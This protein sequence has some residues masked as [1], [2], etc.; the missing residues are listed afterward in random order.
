MLT[1]ARRLLVRLFRSSSIPQRLLLCFLLLSIVP[2]VIIGTA[3]YRQSNA[4]MQDKIGT[5]SNEILHQLQKTVRGEAK[6]IET[7]TDQ[8]VYQPAVQNALVHFGELMEWQKA[9]T[10]WEIDKLVSEKGS[11]LEHIKS[12]RI[13]TM[14]GELL[15]DLGYDGLQDKEVS[16][17]LSRIEDDEAR[18]IWTY[19][20]TLR[21]SDCVLYAREFNRLSDGNPPLGY[22][23]IAIDHAYFNS[24]FENI[25]MGEGA[26]LSLLDSDGTMLY[27]SRPDAALGQLPEERG[28]LQEMTAHRDEERSAFPIRTETGRYLIAYSYDLI[29]DW[30]LVGRI[31]FTYLN[32]ESNRL[33]WTIT[34]IGLAL[35]LV[36][37]AVAYLVA[38]TISQPLR[39]LVG[40]MKEVTRG[41]LEVDVAEEH[42]DELGYLSR[43][44]QRMLAET[45]RLIAQITRVQQ[46]KR[47][48][49]LQML[50]AQINPHFLF[51]T[52]NSLRFTA[53]LSQ[54]DNVSR[55]L[56]ALAELLRSTIVDQVELVPLRQEIRNVDN[57]LTIQRIRYG[58]A[59]ELVIDIPEPLEDCLVLKFMLQPIVENALLH[60]LEG[61]EG[62]GLIT[63]AA[64]KEDDLLL[65]T[66]TDN[67]KGMD[68][69]TREG[70][71]SEK[72]DR[73]LA[74]IGV[75]N[76]DERLRLHYGEAY[77]LNIQSEQGRGTEVT[78][79]IPCM[80]K[81]E[82]TDA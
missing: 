35:I 42:K 1:K 24:A 10:S 22:V 54:A 65:L 38:S 56:G 46:R 60:G 70:L 27:A 5:Y 44:F 34:A 36:C 25:D 32:A 67:G 59:F 16:R 49:E 53:M 78:A 64:Q 17:A 48:A 15:Y 57:Y 33:K 4:A 28:L 21:G 29:S 23:F 69:A 6:K 52:L 31:P 7:L 26:A 66:V 63:I 30:Y 3:S 50:Q 9:S 75:S 73:R 61:Q 71:L 40:G 51:N 74:G 43:T 11:I 18:D 58:N 79:R 13:Y 20:K 62:K 47:E 37:I 76:V 81:E 12:M 68:E 80:W 8:I 45:R 14:K 55:G 72:A 82:E 19:T 41:N 77:G 39:R 2:L